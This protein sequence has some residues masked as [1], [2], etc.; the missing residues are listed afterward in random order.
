ML[1]Q[2]YLAQLR[3]RMTSFLAPLEPH[4]GCIAVDALARGPM[5]A[6]AYTALGRHQ[7]TASNTAATYE[8]V[9]KQRP[10]LFSRA[11]S[12]FAARVPM[13]NDSRSDLRPELTSIDGPLS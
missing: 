7:S 4:I 13:S 2:C 3:L 9:S 10:L 1:V 6:Q 8:G 12:P 11:L 5:L